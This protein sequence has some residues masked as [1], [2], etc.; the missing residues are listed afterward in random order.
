M[1][2]TTFYIAACALVGFAL[3]LTAATAT[4]A[5]SYRIAVTRVSDGDTVRGRK[6]AVKGNPEVRIRLYGIDAPETK[7]RTWDAQ[8]GGKESST[9]LRHMLPVGDVVT[10]N[11]VDVD[12]YKRDVAILTMQDGRVVQEELLRYGHAWVYPQYCKISRC[13]Y[14]RSLESE[15]KAARRGLWHKRNAT[16]PWEWRKGVR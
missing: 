16:P 8:P 2:R 11:V 15:A 14:W 1:N 9:F 12:R 5:D 13:E 6:L 3:L 4:A 7:G 10:V